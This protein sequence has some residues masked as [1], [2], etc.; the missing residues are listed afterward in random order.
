MCFRPFLLVW[1]VREVPVRPALLFREWSGSVTCALFFSSLACCLSCD[2]IGFLCVS[3]GCVVRR[4]A[5]LCT[6]SK[7]GHPGSG[8][9]LWCE[10]VFLSAELRCQRTLLLRVSRM[11]SSYV[12]NPYPHF[13][14]H[15][16]MTEEHDV[17]RFAARRV[18]PTPLLPPRLILPA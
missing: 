13:V 11:P 9:L 18:P 7:P 12:S 4:H 5:P 8:N 6:N 14:V 16:W 10:D 17:R 2:V 15:L 3:C 1:Q